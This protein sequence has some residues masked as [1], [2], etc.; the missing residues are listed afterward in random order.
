MK[1]SFGI[2]T[3]QLVFKDLP[4]VAKHYVE[5]CHNLTSTG[6]FLDSLGGPVN[7][8]TTP[9]EARMVIESTEFDSFK[10]HPASKDHYEALVIN[11][12]SGGPTWV[13]PKDFVTP[14]LKLLA[15]PNF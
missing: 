2:G 13:I 10:E 6:N 5:L 7:R 4:M 1:T 9:E 8:V 14:E 12:N 3:I 15:E 11:N